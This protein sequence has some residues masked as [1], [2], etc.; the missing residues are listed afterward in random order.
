VVYSAENCPVVVQKG[1]WEEKLSSG[2]NTSEDPTDA[3]D[4]VCLDHV[5]AVVAR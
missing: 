4:H 3:R 1:D 2:V 5:W